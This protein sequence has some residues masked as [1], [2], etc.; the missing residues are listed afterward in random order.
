M[1]DNFSLL[2]YQRLQP[3]RLSLQRRESQLHSR[4]CHDGRSEV[5]FINTLTQSFYAVSAL[6]GEH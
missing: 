5:N 6:V 1:D 4:R 2:D 3:F